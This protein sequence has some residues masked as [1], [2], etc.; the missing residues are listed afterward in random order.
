MAARDKDQII[1]KP[2]IANA[3]LVSW[4]HHDI[5]DMGSILL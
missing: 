2:Q 5:V 1:L 4:C 3:R